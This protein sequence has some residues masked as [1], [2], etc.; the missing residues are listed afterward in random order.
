MSREFHLSEKLKGDVR[1][2]IASGFRGGGGRET[3]LGR[4]LDNLGQESGIFREG[5]D[6][7][8]DD[9]HRTIYIIHQASDLNRVVVLIATHSDK[10]P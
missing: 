6:Q 3:E 9:I 1:T 7:A 2:E 5:D 8:V 4:S 10:P